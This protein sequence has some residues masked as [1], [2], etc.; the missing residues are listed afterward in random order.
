[1]AAILLLDLGLAASFIGLLAL[2][3]P[4]RFLGL[5]RRGQGAAVLVMGLL[6]VATAALLPASERSAASPD[7]RLDHF[8]SRWQFDEHHV[9]R[10]HASPQRVESA[11]RSVTATDI[12]FFRLLTWLR[13]PRLPGRGSPETI[14]SAGAA[15]RF[16]RWLSAPGSGCWPRSPLSW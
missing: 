12:R 16:S 9:T 5:R 6:V 13:S 2:L 4:L 14:L 3:R 1:M 10:V 8:V 11:I 15:V 7:S